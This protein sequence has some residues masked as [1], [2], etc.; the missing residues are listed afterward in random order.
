MS[1]FPRRRYHAGSPALF[2]GLLL[3]AVALHG[4]ELAPGAY[5]AAPVGVNV[6]VLA[7]TL[8]G[9]DLT[10]DPSAPIEDG[11]ATIN[12]S[13][14]GFA[15][16]LDVAGRSAQIAI[17]LPYVLGNVEGIYIGEFTKVHRSGIGDP[18]LRFGIN[19]YGA[20]AMNLKEFAG[21]RQRTSI[22]ASLNV[23]IPAGQY[24]PAKLINIGSNRWSFKPEIGVTH[25]FGKWTVEYFGGAWMFTDN[26]NFFGGRLR[27]QDPI[28]STQFHFTRTF[29][30]R[31]WVAFNANFYF[32]GRTTVD[33]TKNLDLQTN[34]RVGV[35]LAVPVA[36]RQS[37]KIAFSRG[38]YTSIG[39]DFNAIGIS[40]QYLWGAGL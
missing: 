33:D 11:K 2:L 17:G 8:Q 37:I 38:A 29:R 14:L 19:L 35:T 6:I 20:P 24:D 7:N 34:S 16:T 15:R 9:G 18:R 31:L 36:R 3:C 32:G 40:Y 4:Q 10:F 1:S 28:G 23:V 26:D 27:K 5:A 25:R 30:P 13:S 22:G 12:A 21:H 39:A